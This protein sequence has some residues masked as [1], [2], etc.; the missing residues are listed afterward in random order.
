MPGTRRILLLSCLVLLPLQQAQAFFCLRFAMG[1]G[2]H[3]R[4]GH[5]AFSP[6]GYPAAPH[7]SW[8][9]RNTPPSVPYPPPYP[10]APAP[11]SRPPVAIPT[12][13]PGM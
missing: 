2:S 12:P 9:L 8:Y 6:R 1:A 3:D 11:R 4:S 10:L 7:P 5:H 13:Q